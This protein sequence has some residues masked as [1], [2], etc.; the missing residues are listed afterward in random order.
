[1]GDKQNEVVIFNPKIYQ[2]KHENTY[3]QTMYMQIHDTHMYTPTLNK[4][5]G[6]VAKVLRQ[7]VAHVKAQAIIY[8]VVVQTLL[9]YGC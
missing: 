2:R 4:R 6:V 3:T 1:M 5:W 8:K 9:L 7:T